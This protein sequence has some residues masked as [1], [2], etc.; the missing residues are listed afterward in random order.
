MEQI[1]I[2]DG[3]F[4]LFG[5]ANNTLLL[6]LIPGDL[7]SSCSHREFHTLPDLLHSWDALPNSYPHTCMPS[8]GAVCT[9]FMMVFDM[10]RPG[11]QPVT[12]LMRDRQVK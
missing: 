9:I 11:R 4:Y 2:K 8:R 6:R 5:K 10:M 12:Y 1:L 3:L 7:L